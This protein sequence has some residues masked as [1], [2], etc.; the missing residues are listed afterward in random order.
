[1]TRYTLYNYWR[2]GTSHRVRIALNLKGLPYDYRA[3]ALTEGA[4]R[5]PAFLAIN[6]QGLL[7]TLVE[8]DADGMPTRVISQSLAILEWLDDA[9]P[10]PPLLPTDPDGRAR[11]RALAT[12]V[13]CDIHPVNNL[14]ILK[15]LE[16]ELGLDSEARNAWC[17]RWISDGFAALEAMLTAQAGTG[18]FCHGDRPGVADICLVPQIFSAG[19]FGTDLGPYP[20]IRRINEACLALPAFADAHPPNQPDAV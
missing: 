13:A 5:S 6:P 11:V 20:T 7:P 12:L 10:T 1:M 15:Y 18:R 4:H 9:H 17:R 16:T 14:R 8:S 19:R 3:V 2:S